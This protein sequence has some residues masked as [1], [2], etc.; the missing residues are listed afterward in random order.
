MIPM[1]QEE[2]RARLDRRLA[3]RP[4]GRWVV[5][6]GLVHFALVNYALPCERLVPHIPQDRFEIPEFD[7]GGRRMAMMSAVPFLDFD[8]HFESLPFARFTFG[9]TNYR[10]YVIHR[11]TGEHAAWFFGTTLG[12]AT[13]AIPRLLWRL[14]WHYARYQV[15][16]R[17]D[18]A[19]GRY[20]RFHY[21][22]RGKWASAEVD[23]EDTGQPVD[24]AEGFGSR[25]ET[26][27]IL[28]HPVDGYFRRGD[29]RLGHYSIWHR[30]MRI[31]S[32]IPRRL[33]FSLYERLGL[34]SADEMARPHSVYLCPEIEFQIHLPPQ[35][36]PGT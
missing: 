2:A 30:E 25:D 27:L 7:I 3:P 1:S 12:S 29:G 13:V 14:P 17:L 19:A 10:V 9:Q 8:F 20:E 18:A 21:S 32:A 16:C 11:A 22:V 6:S 23:V 31:T 15:D 33:Y 24:T 26:M 5:R 34:L 4:M 28:T 36:L 35:P